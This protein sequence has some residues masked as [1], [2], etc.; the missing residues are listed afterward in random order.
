ML[1][2]NAL[3]L[4]LMDYDSE[5]RISAHCAYNRLR[6]HCHGS[7]E[8]KTVESIAS[9][10]SSSDLLLTKSELGGV[11]FTSQE[12]YGG[13]DS[14]V[15]TSTTTNHYKPESSWVAKVETV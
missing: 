10:I 2:V 5:S 7:S 13:D 11:L 1:V 4:E 14:A 6:N 15:N 12:W 9:D 8:V 3:I